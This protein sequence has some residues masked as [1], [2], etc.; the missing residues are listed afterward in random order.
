MSI[1]RGE[2]DWALRASL[3]E[4]LVDAAERAERPSARRFALERL[5]RAL[6]LAD[7]G[8]VRDGLVPRL[9]ALEIPDAT[10]EASRREMPPH[11]VLAPFVATR[12]AERRGIVR[13]VLVSYAPNDDRRGFRLGS[14]AADAIGRAIALANEAVP[15]DAP[16]DRLSLVPL[17]RGALEDADVDGPSLAAAAYLSAL[18][19]FSGR[20]AR[21]GLAVTG[22]LSGPRLVPVEGLTEKLAACGLRGVT[23]LA[24]E[25]PGA[26]ASAELERLSD[27]ASLAAR[28]L[29][30]APL[31]A[32]IEAEV[33]ALR[34]KSDAGWNGYR[35]PAIREDVARVIVRTPERRPELRVE[36]LTRL[37]AA[38]RHLGRTS[39][40]L[41]ALDEAE[42]ILETDE[43]DEAVP[44]EHRVRLARQKA[45]T[46][47]HAFRIAEA[48][49]AA[50]LSERIARRARL[51]SERIASLGAIG[52]VAMAADEPERA[53]AAFREALALGMRQRPGDVARSRAYLLEALGALGRAEEARA[54][55]DEAL[56]EAEADARRGKPGKIEW[57]RASYAQ[58]LLGM[59]A[60]DAVLEVLDDPS[61]QSAI[62]SQPLPGLRARR[63]LGLAQLALGAPERR[64]AGRALLEASP[65]SYAALEPFLAALAHA[66]VLLALADRLE[67]GERVFEERIEKS[68]AVL[69]RLPT[70]EAFVRVARG[71]KD[72][73]ARASAMREL[74]S[75]VARV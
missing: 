65:E 8:T 10:I 21:G 59:G 5:E 1:A 32:D 41:R 24:P 18:A 43:G 37:A 17:Q 9:R 53:E 25:E 60:Y 40:S 56:R 35:W 22:A 50:T 2:L 67:A 34:V 73:K 45:M 63:T 66:N 52:L 19:L 55:Y 6:E 11:A 64:E 15:S 54:Q 47:L 30:R 39:A 26:S 74:S 48:R 36:V 44:D 23:L 61:V 28:A 3:I 62:A 58:A 13:A 71:A 12:G 70:M 27:V 38:E 4:P 51:R 7:P 75:R 14:T 49:D 16:L 29:E 20:R 31:D 33:R 42:A 57:V 72:R 46:L 69:E 68:L